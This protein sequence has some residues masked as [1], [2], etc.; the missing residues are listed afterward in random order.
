MPS[1]RC[2]AR[3][4]DHRIRREDTKYT[5]KSGATVKRNFQPVLQ[6]RLGLPGTLRVPQQIRRRTRFAELEVN[7]SIALLAGH[8]FAL[9]REHRAFVVNLFF[10]KAS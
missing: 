1:L 8:F 9:L 10:L 5:K 4:Q 7:G 3:E 6:P 2:G